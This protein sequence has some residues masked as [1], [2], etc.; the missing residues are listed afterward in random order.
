MNSLILRTAT[1]ILVSLMLLFSIFIMLRG[2][3]EPGGGFVGGLIASTAFGLY[4]VAYGPQAVRNAIYFD[5][6]KIA[7]FGLGLGIL[8][9]IIGILA[10]GVFLTGTWTHLGGIAIGTPVL[11]DLGVYFVVVGAVMTLILAMEEEE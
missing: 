1:K 5:P 8:A 7:M 6:R 11:F 3:N 9:G 10:K 4:A 2:H